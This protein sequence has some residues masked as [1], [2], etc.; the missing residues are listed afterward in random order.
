MNRLGPRVHPG[1]SVTM[2]KEGA[3]QP[4]LG[5]MSSPGTGVESTLKQWHPARERGSSSPRGRSSAVSRRG[6]CVR[7]EQAA[8]W[9]AG[10]GRS[11]QASDWRAGAP[12]WRRK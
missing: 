10:V 11:Q 1:T 9:T 6:R 3:S 2:A 8:D 5:H 12:S 7:A 4:D